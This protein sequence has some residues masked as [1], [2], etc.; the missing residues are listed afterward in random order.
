MI[1]TTSIDRLIEVYRNRGAVELIK[2]LGRQIP[3]Q[4]T[5]RVFGSRLWFRFLHLVN[6]FRYQTVPEPYT[7]EFVDPA[8]VRYRSARHVNSNRS[9][10]RDVG[11]LV[12]GD[13]DIE[14][15]TREYDLE[16]DM[17]YQAIEERFRDGVSWKDTEYVNRTLETLREDN[18][19]RTWRAV[20]RN[21]ADLWERCEQLDKLYD[22]IQAEGY[23]SKQEIF[24]SE[25]TDPMGYYPRTFKYSIDEVMIDRGRDGD[26][27]L[28]DGQ[29]RLFIAQMLDLEEIPVLVAVRHADYV[30]DNP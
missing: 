14:S 26:P 10:W 20:V 13:W 30:E 24:A 25:S 7:L 12:G 29:H 22:R 1:L 28:V 27:L 21:E 17:L 23:H 2:R 18:G 3:Y 15:Q 6:S 8:D 19:E 4:I 5:E 9:R 16:N 11:K